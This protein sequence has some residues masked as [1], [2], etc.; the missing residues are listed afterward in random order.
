MD[1]EKMG[2]LLA[3][4]RK[5]KGLTQKQL[6]DVMHISDRTISKWERG[7]GFPDISLLHVLSDLFEVNIK[8]LLSGDLEE[9][10]YDGGNMK[11]LKFYVCPDC[12]NVLFS[13]SS[14]ELSCCGR[15]LPALESKPC[16]AAHEVQIEDVEYEHYLTV[17]HEMQKEHYISFIAHG[18]YDS[19]H[20]VKLYPEQNPEVRM[21]LM[22]GGM[23]YLYCSKDGLFAQP[24]TRV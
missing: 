15:R 16:D 19:V 6:A 11:R 12:A 3:R 1:S 4:L 10:Q 22:R 21:P 7:A 23:L 14:A 5:E 20:L 9:N 2:K 13:S 17:K 18:G 8:T 24:V